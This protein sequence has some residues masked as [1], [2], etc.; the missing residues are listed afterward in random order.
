M[1]PCA[2]RCHLLAQLAAV[3]LAAARLTCAVHCP[4]VY[5]V[6][7]L[8]VNFWLVMI[9]LLQVGFPLLPCCLPGS[10]RCPSRLPYSVPHQTRI[11]PGLA[12]TV[13]PETAATHK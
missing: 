10:M 11:V 6:P 3:T 4:Q 1:Q 5:I 2:W 8:C 13:H 12:C 7:Y 9:T